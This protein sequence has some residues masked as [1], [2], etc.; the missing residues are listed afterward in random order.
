MCRKRQKIQLQDSQNSTQ[1]VRALHISKD[2][3]FILA[4][5]DDRLLRAWNIETGQLKFLGWGSALLN[6]NRFNVDLQ[7][8]V[9]NKVF[10]VIIRSGH[11]NETFFSFYLKWSL[12][13]LNLI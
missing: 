12:M 8:L 6:K 1:P 4:G 7:L 3:N 11:Y 5:G 13:I 9:Q 10:N 2:A